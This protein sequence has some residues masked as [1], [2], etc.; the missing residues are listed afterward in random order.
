MSKKVLVISTSPR[1]GGNSDYLCDQ[2]IRG[3]REAG[4]EVEKIYFQD[5]KINFCK[6]C[7]A[8]NTTHKCVQKDDMEE[9]LGKMVDADVLV[10]GSPV[11]FYTI[12]GQLKT[13]IDRTVPRYTEFRGKAYLLATLADREKDSIADT[14]AAFDGYMDC[15]GQVELGGVVVGYGAWQKGD[16]VGNPAVEEAYRA[17]K[18]C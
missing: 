1:K 3:A 11:Y 17:G 12:C 13:L 6:G 10:F 7:G 4:H 8:C 9:V 18:E 5:K 16:I 15:L 14:R 2:F